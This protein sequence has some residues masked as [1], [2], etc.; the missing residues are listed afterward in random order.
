MITIIAAGAITLASLYASAAILIF[1][2]VFPVFLI[3]KI[4]RIER[5]EDGARYIMFI[6]CTCGANDDD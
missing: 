1:C 5:V 4:A 3:A 6:C 2:L